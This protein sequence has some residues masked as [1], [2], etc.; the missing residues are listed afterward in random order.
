MIV[1]L[2]LALLCFAR[3]SGGYLPDKCL[4]GGE[5]KVAFALVAYAHISTPPIP[6]TAVYHITEPNC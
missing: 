5:R 2:C 3:H 1:L 4:K 6:L